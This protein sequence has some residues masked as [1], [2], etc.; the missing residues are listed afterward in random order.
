MKNKGYI[1]V[2]ASLVLPVFLFFLSGMAQIAMLFPA[3]V[4]IHQALA[5]AAEY[6]ALYGYLEQKTEAQLEN[7]EQL[8]N[9]NQGEGITGLI[10]AVRLNRQFQSCLGKNAYVE[11]VLL[12]GSRGISITIKTDKDNPKLFTAKASYL[13][14]FSAPLLG[15]I[16]IPFS[17]EIRQKAFVGY[18]REEKEDSYVYITPNQ[19]VY[20][21]RRSCTHL[22]LTVTERDGGQR[23]SCVPCKFC[24]K[25]RQDIIYVAK[26]SNVYH[27][28]RD[29]LGLKRT[30]SRV[31]LNEVR[32]KGKCSRCAE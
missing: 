9:R 1:T 28:K 25:G 22:S 29:C 24:G 3:E 5:E 26:S 7:R 32:G 21:L 12:N 10:N 11:T 27:N 30:V 13:A 19:E 4:H 17:T 8:E 16:T 20:H 31:R 18:G 23:G 2:E 14:V 6:T 15:K